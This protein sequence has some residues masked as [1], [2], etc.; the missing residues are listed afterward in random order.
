MSPL[1]DA[2]PTD[3][4][5][6][7][8]EFASKTALPGASTGITSN[9][10]DSFKNSLFLDEFSEDELRRLVLLQ[11]ATGAGSMSGPLMDSLV[12]Y[13][14]NDS[15]SG[16]YLFFTPGV[17]EIWQFMGASTAGQTTG[18]NTITY[19]IGV[20]PAAATGSEFV[21]QGVKWINY[22]SSSN[23][24]FPIIESDTNS[25][26]SYCSADYPCFLYIEGSGFTNFNVN[27]AF[28]R[29]R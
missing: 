6:V 15:S 12:I 17:G 29:V 28:V 16:G 23:G 13:N 8:R 11:M 2:P 10:I 1:P 26:P 3:K 25:E 4:S 7:Y 21:T 19:N 24:Q 14:L 5:R 22:G 9:L 20:C 18:S 27:A